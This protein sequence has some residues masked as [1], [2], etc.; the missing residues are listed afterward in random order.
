MAHAPA[1]TRHEAD[2]IQLAALGLTNSQIAERLEL[3][4]H[5]IK[6]HLSSVYSKLAVSNRTQAAV[7]YLNLSR[8]DRG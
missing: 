7:A 4:T 1:L 6:F 8:E 5:A 3:T 2:V